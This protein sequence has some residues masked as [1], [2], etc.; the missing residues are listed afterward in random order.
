LTNHDIIQQR[1]I[2]QQLAYTAF[3]QPHEL[4]SYM[5]CIQAQDFAGAKWAIGNRVKGI[6]DALVEK[7]FN[8]GKILRTHILRP[9][10]HFV[11]PVDI[12]WMLKLT[13][14]QVKMLSAGYLRRKGIDAAT[15]NKSKKIFENALTGGK[16]LSREE[17]VPLFKDQQIKTNDDHLAFLLLEAE[18]DGLICSGPRKGKRF[19]YSLLEER[20]P[21]A[22][23]LDK[24]EA[25]AK[26]AIKY[27]ISRGP[28][29]V[30]DFAWWSGLSITDA[31]KGTEA[32]R[33]QL[34]HEVMDGQTYWSSPFIDAGKMSANAVQLLPAYDE[35]NVAYKNRSFSINENHNTL[36]GNGIFKPPLVV[37]G[38]IAGAWKRTDGKNKAS[39]EITPFIKLSS[40]ATKKI[41]AC[42]EHYSKFL[43]KQCELKIVPVLL[44]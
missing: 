14:P 38:K 32:N 41:T 10:W 43:N 13:A 7:E 35:Y 5:G 2:N 23:Q 25:L 37:D 40:Q 33:S 6:T 27:F 39:I 44:S 17:L 4:I 18:L 24:E 28:A 16:H 29:T 22:K 20:V 21:N 1:L 9:T 11:S 3:T 36:S 26:L 42:S 34:I 19:T 12:G 15:L 30:H 31:R 8:E